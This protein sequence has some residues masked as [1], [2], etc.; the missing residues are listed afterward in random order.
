[1]TRRLAAAVAL[2]L[3]AAPVAAE[4]LSLLDQDLGALAERL[5]RAR[6]DLGAAPAVP[7]NPAALRRFDVE[8]PAT[9]GPLSRAAVLANRRALDGAAI[10]PRTLSRARPTALEIYRAPR[11]PLAAPA[12]RS[13]AHRAGRAAPAAVKRTPHR[14]LCLWR[15]SPPPRP[16]PV[17]GRG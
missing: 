12:G 6:I 2:A 15:K 13:G 14:L 8:R 10:D 1:M 5:A 9:A 16:S 4:P 17:K 7:R 3:W 11:P